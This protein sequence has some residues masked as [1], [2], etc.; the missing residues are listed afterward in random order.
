MEHSHINVFSTM[1]LNGI[2][3]EIK[4]ENKI[5]LCNLLLS[6]NLLILK[7]EKQRSLDV[8]ANRT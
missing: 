5:V 1:K 4:P 2:E 8:Y 3:F 6:I 7:N